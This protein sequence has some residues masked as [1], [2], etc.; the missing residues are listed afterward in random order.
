MGP[1]INPGSPAL[2]A[3]SVPTELLRKPLGIAKDKVRKEIQIY[4]LVS[5]E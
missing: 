3:D 1:E 4:N 2:Q 5:L